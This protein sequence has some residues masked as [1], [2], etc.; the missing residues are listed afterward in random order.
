[1]TV[2]YPPI[3]TLASVLVRYNAG[4]EGRA[5][6]SVSK[7]IQEVENYFT[8]GLVPSKQRVSYECV[9]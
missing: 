7:G 4:V 9:A 2:T 8:S 1:V 3:A 6:K 5:G